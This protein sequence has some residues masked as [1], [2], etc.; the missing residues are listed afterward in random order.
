MPLACPTCGNAEVFL[1]KT[2]QAHTV[3]LRGTH[4]DVLEETHPAVAETLCGECDADIDLSDC[5]EATRRELL[6]T[7]GAR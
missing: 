1:V 5:D 2:V 3:R 6:L 4:V 7:L